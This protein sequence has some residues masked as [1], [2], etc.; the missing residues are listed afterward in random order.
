MPSISSD[1]CLPFLTSE[2]EGH[3]LNRRDQ[4]A[5][6][7]REGTDPTRQSDARRKN[8]RLRHYRLMTN[9]QQNDT[10]KLYRVPA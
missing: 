7:D 2:T 3:Q 1:D 5:D 9:I 8:T 4:A 10:E 6:D